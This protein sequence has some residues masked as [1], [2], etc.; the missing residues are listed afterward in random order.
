VHSEK[1]P[2]IHTLITPMSHST[3]MGEVMALLLCTVFR[4]F[5]Y[6]YEF[7]NPPAS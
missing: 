2:S 5:E 6:R 1:F 3:K 7:M 4:F